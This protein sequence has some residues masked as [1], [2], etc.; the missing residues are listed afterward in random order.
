MWLKSIYP[1]Y[2]YVVKI[3]LNWVLVNN[4]CNVPLLFDINTSNAPLLFDFN[5]IRK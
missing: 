4:T 1:T 5:T 2:K 3:Y